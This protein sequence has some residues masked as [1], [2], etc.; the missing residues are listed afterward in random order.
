MRS[1]R[2]EWLRVDSGSFSIPSEQLSPPTGTSSA[3]QGLKAFVS[4]ARPD[5]N[6]FA[7]PVRDALVELGARVWFDQDE[8]P[9][10]AALTAGL[11]AII[12]SCDLYVMC[13]TDESSKGGG[14]A[15]QE[16]AWAMENIGTKLR[17]A[18][19]V[20]WPGTVLPT[21]VRDW[22]CVE[23]GG[24]DVT[25][26]RRDLEAAFVRSSMQPMQ[27]M[28]L[29]REEPPALPPLALGADRAALLSR[30]RHARLFEEIDQESLCVCDE[31]SS[32]AA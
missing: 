23:W 6:D 12:E 15:T 1:V 14:Y 31:G 29:Q 9:S 11:S 18:L 5:A 21:L 20:C 32:A 17:H 2:D 30:A 19:I 3:L 10:A 8:H 4:Y 25:T 22:P 13:A 16:F 28:V 7:A 27:P 26:L 24:P